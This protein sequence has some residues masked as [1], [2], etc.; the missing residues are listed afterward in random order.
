MYI[1]GVVIMLFKL[2]NVFI[3]I[4][5]RISFYVC[6]LMWLLMMCVFMKYFSLCIII[7]KMS[8]VIVSFNDVVIFIIMMVVLEMRLFVIGI[9]FVMKV[10]RISD[11]EYG[12]CWL[13]SGSVFNR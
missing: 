4:S 6:V 12:M 8:D 9:S 11:L 3:M 2:N 5:V 7:R 10:S 13:N 1:I